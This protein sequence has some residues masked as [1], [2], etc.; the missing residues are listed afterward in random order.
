MYLHYHGLELFCSAVRH[1]NYLYE[2]LT[3]PLR[4]IVHEMTYNVSS[5]TLNPLYRTIPFHSEP[6]S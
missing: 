2:F 1:F 3:S 5:G 4:A 6:I